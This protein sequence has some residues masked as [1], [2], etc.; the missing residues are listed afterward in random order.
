VEK[1]YYP[2]LGSFRFALYKGTTHSSRREKN[3]SFSCG[4]RLANTMRRVWLVGG[5]GLIMDEP[6][7]DQRSLAATNLGILQQHDV[8]FLAYL[9]ERR[10]MEMKVSTNIH[11]IIP[12]KGRKKTKK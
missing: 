9:Q 7:S 6:A 8:M 3:A 11:I 4:P 12:K 10:R 5:Q 1:G 2:P